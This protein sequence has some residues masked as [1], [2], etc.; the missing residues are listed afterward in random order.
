MA[1]VDGS[2]MVVPKLVL[3]VAMVRRGVKGLRVYCQVERNN[4]A[5]R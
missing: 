2:R 5:L 1:D 4:L 3:C